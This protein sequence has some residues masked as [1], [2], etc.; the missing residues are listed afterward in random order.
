MNTSPIRSC[1]QLT[2]KLEP[3]STSTPI[4]T[5]SS[6]QI[7]KLASIKC[8][9]VINNN[10]NANLTSLTQLNHSN[11]TLLS[12][13]TP[14]TLVA[15]S[16]GIGG[17]T[18]TTLG[19]L[20]QQ[21]QQQQQQQ[22]NL[23]LTPL[24]NNLNGNATLLTLNGNNLIIQ[25]PMLQQ[26]NN[27]HIIYQT[28][29]TVLQQVITNTASLHKQ[30]PGML[31]SNSNSNSICMNNL[32]QNEASLLNSNTTSTSSAS[33]SSAAQNSNHNS[34]NLNAKSVAAAAKLVNFLIVKSENQQNVQDSHGLISFSSDLDSQPNENENVQAN[35]F[36]N[37]DTQ[38][39]EQNQDAQQQIE[40]EKDAKS[41]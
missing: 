7:S 13:S 33:S 22:Q 24:T 19:S 21:H 14:L 35:E 2:T 15:T 3:S 9:G 34:T 31:L 28:Q 40:D 38:N 16:N 1:T 17:I 12:N 39:E 27:Q 23:G 36:N 37:N 5:S 29:P 11:N 6:K 18:L 26:M 41:I 32:N 10:N 20:H 25:Q 30:A 4:S 8:N